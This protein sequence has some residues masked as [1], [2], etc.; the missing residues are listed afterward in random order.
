MREDR[1]DLLPAERH[2]AV[3]RR[4]PLA[5]PARGRGARSTSPSRPAS[6]SRAEICS[7]EKSKR[8]LEDD[9]ARL[10]RRDAGQ[11]RAELA[12]AAR[13]APPPGPDPRR[14]PARSS[15]GS[16]SQRRTRW[17]CG[18]VAAR[19]DDEPVEPGRELRLAAELA[20]PHAE[21][22]ERLLRG[23]ARVL[24]IARSCARAAR[25]A[26]RAARRAPP[27]RGVAVFCSRHQDRVAQPLVDE[28]RVGPLRST[29]SDGPC[30][31]AGCTAA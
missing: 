27:A 15:S 7:N 24:G 30:A 21:L 25:R 26:G 6:P 2:A 5:Q 14:R 4:K 23:V 3:M 19:V 9:H 17:R 10:L 22:R 12:R 16:G 1:L 20:E 13:R 11:A 31:K 8:V 28:R 18:D 29:E